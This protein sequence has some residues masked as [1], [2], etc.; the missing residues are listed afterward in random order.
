MKK[1]GQIAELGMG[2][3]GIWDLG[4]T[5]PFREEVSKSGRCVDSSFRQVSAVAKT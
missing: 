5:T 2:W 1:G 4:H 3:V